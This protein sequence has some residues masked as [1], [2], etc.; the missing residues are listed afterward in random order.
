[1]IIFV[2]NL[3]S[4]I[5]PVFKMATP[6]KLES[7]T[8]DLASLHNMLE[9]ISDVSLDFYC[10][11]RDTN[12]CSDTFQFEQKHTCNHTELV[13][14]VTIP[15]KTILYTWEGMTRSDGIIYS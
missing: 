15:S 13:V 8:V 2:F 9:G 5:K 12:T 3:L 6:L 14:L 4:G 7:E 11:L 1:M 10:S